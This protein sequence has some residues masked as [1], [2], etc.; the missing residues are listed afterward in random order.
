[1]YLI[2]NQKNRTYINNRVLPSEKEIEISNDDVLKLANEEF[3][4][5]TQ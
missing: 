5:K 2:F 4:F 3:L 1:M